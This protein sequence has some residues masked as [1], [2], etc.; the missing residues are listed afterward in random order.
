MGLEFVGSQEF[1]TTGKHMRS[2]CQKWLLVVLMMFG[3]AANQAQAGSVIRYFFDGILPRSVNIAALRND[4]R[5]P[6][7]SLVEA[8]PGGLH[9]D[10]E[11]NTAFLES[12][13]TGNPGVDDYGSL[14]RGWLYPTTGAAYDFY[15]T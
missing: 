11:R 10:Q 1:S 12:L 4:P 9:D 7:S 13:T 15:I 6:S 8:G 2:T 3:V 5:Y 14:I